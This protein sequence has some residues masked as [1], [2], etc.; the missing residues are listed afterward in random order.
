MRFSILLPSAEGK[1]AGGNPLAPDMFDYRS[2]NT[3]NYFSELNPERRALI[4]ALQT[5]MEEA[6][7]AEL[8]ALLGVKGDTLEEAVAINRD[9]YR[10]PLMAAV[11][12]YSPGVMYAA[13]DFAGLPTGSQRRLLENG[14]IFS[15]LFGLLRPD[16]LIP[17]YRLRMDAK[18]GDL[19]KVASYWRPVL[20]DHLN[21]LLKGQAV[22]NLLSGTH[23]A[24]W[25]DAGTYARMIRL[26]FYREDE[27][28]ERTAVSHGVKE[29]RGA[30]VAFIVNETADGVEA[31]E[32]WEA[33]DGYEVD[34]DGSEI[35]ESG[36][37]TVV[38]VSSP[39]WEARR[40]ARRK[41]RAQEEAE[42]AAAKAARERDED[43][44]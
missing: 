20:S 29:L 26:K 3:F 4:D 31:L 36:G 13:M 10:S 12:R 38:M 35:D 9:I 32:E 1:E 28:G 16:D 30:L 8:G 5:Q 25:D 33:P 18:V 34:H 6:T 11:D 37:G 23:E 21:A 40:K 2:S 39:G 17:N 27:S 15:G 42:A 41:A 7:E 14:V 19:G 22:W 43:D 44:D 24:A